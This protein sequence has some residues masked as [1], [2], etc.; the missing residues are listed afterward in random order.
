MT[1]PKKKQ[2]DLLFGVLCP[3]NYKLITIH[4]TGTEGNE[5]AQVRY[6][7]KICP[8]APTK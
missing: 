5:V 1:K 4:V 8:P 3:D 2:L 7:G 6:D